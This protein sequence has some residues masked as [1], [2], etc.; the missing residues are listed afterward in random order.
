MP[1]RGSQHNDPRRVDRFRVNLS[2]ARDALTL[3]HPDGR[4]V[5]RAHVVAWGLFPSSSRLVGFSLFFGREKKE[6]EG[7]EERSR[8]KKKPKKNQKK[9]KG[10]DINHRG[11]VT[12]GKE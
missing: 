7:R 3:S 5:H 8:L 2:L 9:N 11:W 1:L 6:E 12:E 10:I 4:F